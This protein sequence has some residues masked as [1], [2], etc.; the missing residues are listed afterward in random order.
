MK[1]VALSGS[2]RINGNTELMIRTAFKPLQA[3]GIE[4]EL[5]Q[6]GGK[7]VRGC[8][9]CGKCGDIQNRTCIFTTDPVNKIIEKFAEADGIIIGS[10]TYFADLS[11]DL[12]S[13]LDRVFFVSLKNGNL[14]KHKVGA[15]VVAVRR[16]GATQAFDSINHYF[17]ISGMF[18]VGSSYWNMGFGLA[19]GDVTEDEEGMNNMNDLGESMAL[20]LKKLKS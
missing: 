9:A 19:P 17:Q 16:G 6:V 11:G 4:T 2:P 12:K 20:L 7:G 3:A 14:F 13:T 5:V 18:I 10:P 15:A 8:T 1:V